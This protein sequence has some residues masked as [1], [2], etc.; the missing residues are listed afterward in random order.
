M[1]NAL[2]ITPIE[3]TTFGAWIHDLDV[4]D[5]TESEFDAVY[6]AWLEY[7]LLIFPDQFLS[8]SEQDD[9]AGRF[10]DLEFTAA[11]ISNIT[12]DGA[13]MYAARRTP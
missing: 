5:L 6:D 4:R 11:A 1:V 9:F 8:K 2:N 12:N 3:G 10:G 7:G 13:I